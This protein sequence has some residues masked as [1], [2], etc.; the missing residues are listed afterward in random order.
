MLIQTNPLVIRNL[1]EQIGRW[2]EANFDENRSKVYPHL[3]LDSLAP[4]MGITEELGELL[5]AFY[6]SDCDTTDDPITD[7][8]GDI[9]VYL[10]DYARREGI[11]LALL[12]PADHTIPATP[13]QLPELGVV[14]GRLFH[15]VLKRHQGIRGFEDDSK[16]YSLRDAVVKDILLGLYL[17]SQPFGSFEEILTDTWQK[18]V[19]KRD[20]KKHPLDAANK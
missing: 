12:L 9:G 20:W 1:Q 3:V 10:C 13:M 15:C 5:E 4:L 11:L 16:F 7:A 2:A 18:V 17:A 19:S 8:L 6:T 14:I